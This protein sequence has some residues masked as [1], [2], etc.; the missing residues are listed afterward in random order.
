LA[1][2]NNALKT[3]IA[4]ENQCTTSAD[5]S[6]L[7]VGARACGGPSGYLAYS[8]KSSNFQDI[9]LMAQLTNHLE[10]QYNLENSVVSICSIV[11]APGVACDATKKCVTSSSSSVPDIQ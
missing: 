2:A 11:T 5:C 1:A 7:P 8:A 9:Q 10:Q 4:L 3:A 6:V